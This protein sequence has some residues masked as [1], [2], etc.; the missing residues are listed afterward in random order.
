MRHEDFVNCRTSLKNAMPPQTS[1]NIV[2]VKTPANTP[3][4]SHTLKNY[5]SKSYVKNKQINN[6]ICFPG[7][8][9]SSNNETK[10]MMLS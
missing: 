4:L 10:M 9:E 1:R 5:P 3:I 2:E 7:K 8:E 6:S